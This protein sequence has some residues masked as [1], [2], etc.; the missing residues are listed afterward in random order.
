[1]RLESLL[2]LEA[3]SRSPTTAAR[4]A[5][6]GAAEQPLIATMSR[7]GGHVVE[8]VAYSPNGRIVAAG[9]GVGVEL[10]NVRTRTPNGVPFDTAWEVNGVAFS[11]NGKLLAVAEADA[12]PDSPIGAAVVYRISGP[13]GDLPILAS[14]IRWRERGRLLPFRRRGRGEHARR[15]GAAVE[16]LGA[17]LR[18]GRRLTGASSALAV[19]FNRPALSLP[20]PS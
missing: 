18:A 14:R 11:P 15:S 8:A 13:Q 7:V 1:M 3:F 16:P 20:P 9:T 4:S 10:W 5:L 6:I 17:H 12:S 19:A 2:G